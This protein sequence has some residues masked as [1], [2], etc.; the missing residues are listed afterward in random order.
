MAAPGAEGR[1]EELPNDL[2]AKAARPA[3]TSL[4]SLC[5]HNNT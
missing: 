4:S 5:K 1:T 2:M 3:A